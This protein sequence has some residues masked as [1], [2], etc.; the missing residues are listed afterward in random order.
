MS[1]IRNSKYKI[2]CR[3]LPMPTNITLL[4]TFRFSYMKKINCGYLTKDVY[5]FGINCITYRA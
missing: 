2:S 4:N 3:F 5:I 1:D